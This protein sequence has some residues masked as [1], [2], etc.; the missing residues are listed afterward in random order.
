MLNVKVT[1]ILVRLPS[2]FRF[3][4]YLCEY[5]KY[6]SGQYFISHYYY[7]SWANEIQHFLKLNLFAEKLIQ[8]F[9]TY[10]Y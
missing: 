7:L 5:N 3:A 6:F 1:T 10:G 2:F 9:K 4:C 8:C